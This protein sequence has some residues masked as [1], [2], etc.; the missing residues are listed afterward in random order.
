MS[1]YFYTYEDRNTGQLIL[2]AKVT[3]DNL[4][5]LGDIAGALVIYEGLSLLFKHEKLGEEIAELGDYVISDMAGGYWP[6]DY[7]IFEAKYK[8]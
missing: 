4:V 2:A 8:R 7:E 1:E 6:M 3:E 5:E